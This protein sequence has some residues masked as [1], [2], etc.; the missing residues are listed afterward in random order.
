MISGGCYN[1]KGNGRERG[2]GKLGK[3]TFE[4]DER[5]VW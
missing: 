5:E 4:K 3:L 1:L 2:Q